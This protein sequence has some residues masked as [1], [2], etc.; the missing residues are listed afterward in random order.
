MEGIKKGMGEEVRKEGGTTDAVGFPRRN[1]VRISAVGRYHSKS[2]VD[3]LEW[4]KELVCRGRVTY[5]CRVRKYV[6]CIWGGLRGRLTHIV[7]GRRCRH[8]GTKYMVARAYCTSY[9]AAR[10]VP[11][12][13]NKSLEVEVNEGQNLDDREK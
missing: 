8:I 1:W 7:G 5:G 4:C 10:K 11:W 12:M 3:S 6:M 13:Q 2:R 9:C